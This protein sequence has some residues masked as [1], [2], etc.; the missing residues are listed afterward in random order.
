MAP[1][2]SVMKPSAVLKRPAAKKP[3]AAKEEPSAEPN[4]EQESDETF[5]KRATSAA[6]SER[7]FD[8]FY[9]KCFYCGKVRSIRD[10]V[11]KEF[12]HLQLEII[13]IKC[14]GG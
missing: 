9:T 5:I 2:T 3:S 7:E 6:F 14:F 10:V 13:C 11:F 8:M 4:V 1:K 12:Q